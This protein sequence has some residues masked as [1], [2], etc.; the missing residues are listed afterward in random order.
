MTTASGCLSGLT[1]SSRPTSSQ[2][3]RKTLHPNYTGPGNKEQVRSKHTVWVS[4]ESPEKPANVVSLRV[5]MEG[6]RYRVP[7]IQTSSCRLVSQNPHCIEQSAA[8]SRMVRVTHIRSRILQL[9]G[10][11]GH[12]LQELRGFLLGTSRLQDA[13][14][15]KRPIICSHPVSD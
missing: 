8:T 7:A 12:S 10:L 4:F 11:S 2:K 9:E 15:G 3:P 14:L 5:M 6:S 13:R 1:A